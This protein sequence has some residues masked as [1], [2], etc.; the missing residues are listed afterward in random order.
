MNLRELCQLKGFSD[1]LL[2]TFNF[3]PLFFE[4]VVLPDLQAGGAT[5]ITVLADADQAIPAIEAARGQIF[6]L[7]RRYRLIPITG[8][9]SF[10][11]K[12]CVR[13]SRE[14]GI[15]A[16][17]SNNLTR[18]GWL[19]QRPDESISGNRELVTAIRVEANSPMAG[20]LR[21]V[22][23]DLLGLPLTPSD[24]RAIEQTLGVN[25][26]MESA[27]SDPK[28]AQWLVTGIDQSL[29]SVLQERWA[30]RHFDRLQMV[31]GS[32]DADADMIRWV[33][34]TFGIREA[35]IHIDLD[36]CS[37]APSQ[38]TGLDCDLKLV[39]YDGCPRTHLKLAVF[40]AD[41]GPSAAIVGSANCSDSAWIRSRRE[42]G[43]VESV[44][45][46]DECD[47]SDFQAF[48]RSETLPRPWSEVELEESAA[49]RQDGPAESVRLLR[50]LELDRSLGR[51]YVD[52]DASVSKESA[53][54]AVV[55]G[56]PVAL[57]P[58]STTGQWVGPE[59]DLPQN[60]IQ[61]LFGHVDIQKDGE[62]TQTN[63]VWVNDRDAIA[64][65][66][67][68]RSSVDR[69]MGFSS[70]GTAAEY[71][72]LLS[73]MRIVANTL[74]ASAEDFAD[75]GAAT[76]Q[77]RSPETEGP[78]EP[79]DPKTLLRSLSQVGGRTSSTTVSGAAFG[80][81]SLTGVM[82]ILFAEAAD[83]V[84][85][86]DFDLTDIES[87]K[88]AE[89][90]D[91]DQS[92]DRATSPPDA[93]A[94]ADSTE[95]PTQKQADR[96][97]SQLTTFIDQIGEPSFAQTCTARRLQ[98]AV[99][100]PIC[101]AR[102]V[103][104]GPW[105]KTMSKGEIEKEIE[106]LCEILLRRQGR[107]QDPK[108]GESHQV[109][110]LLQEVRDRY[111]SEDRLETFEQIIGDGTLWLV[112]S[113][114]LWA[115]QQGRSNRFQNNLILRDVLNCPVLIN[116]A[117]PE[118]LRPLAERLATGSQAPDLMASLES[119]GRKFEDLEGY[120]QSH[121]EQLKVVVCAD[122][123]VG[124]WLWNHAVGFARIED[125]TS[126]SKGKV[127]IPARARTAENVGFSF[128]TNLRTA[129]ERDPDLD[130]LFRQLVVE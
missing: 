76:G 92:G 40:E 23:D 6:F 80:T 110:P 36:R 50:S 72:Q 67:E 126:P 42:N 24:Q 57:T 8:G 121:E 16:C 15:V 118:H 78:P 22:R 125:A 109:V 95:E 102:F 103:G 11:P 38:L 35:V 39:G 49:D 75:A 58:T 99:A 70:S 55:E 122:P 45:I 130:R 89:E 51:V 81:M 62:H 87:A 63:R 37:F 43:N 98:Q 97:L 48:Y 12:I 5:R 129:A 91:L 79:V 106:R 108:T 44:V 56:S 41:N 18:S 90:A 64:R 20:D 85:S 3:D 104:R 17:G 107:T 128:Y 112:L 9:G 28:E 71:Q 117:L 32:T 83:A 27:P 46:H 73:D 74:L 59:P 111:E 100:F 82:R 2:T 29:A 68:R 114:A 1:T 69:I 53:S 127:H 25:W 21:R 86:G 124:D 10:H 14:G 61:S 105:A 119:I 84:Q 65:A 19:G 54:T 60:T 101:V 93:S 13:L 113:A 7:G 88:S 31:T 120:L 94:S 66:A 123:K 33:Q 34:R 47:P 30:G 116:R 26:L 4:R 115:G 96:L 52:L 77:T